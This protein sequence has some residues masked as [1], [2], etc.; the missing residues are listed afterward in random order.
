MGRGYQDTFLVK[1]P[2]RP[3]S[4][5]AKAGS[6]LPLTEYLQIKPKGQTIR[7]GGTES[8]G[9]LNLSRRISM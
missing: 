6:R 4:R 9:P 7:E 3:A 2:S 1:R 5:P 8:Y